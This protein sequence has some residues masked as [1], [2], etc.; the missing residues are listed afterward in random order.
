MDAHKEHKGPEATWPGGPKRGWF[1]HRETLI[2]L[3]LILLRAASEETSRS[4]ARF[5]L[6]ESHSHYHDDTLTEYKSLEALNTIHRDSKLENQS[7]HS[8]TI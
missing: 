5:L 6:E 2:V 7:C 3:L 8:Q 4:K 1:F